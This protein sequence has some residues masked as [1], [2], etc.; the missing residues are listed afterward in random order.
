MAESLKGRHA[1]MKGVMEETEER[2][3]YLVRWKDMNGSPGERKFDTVEESHA[4]FLDLVN[5]TRAQLAQQ[6][7][8][9][10]Y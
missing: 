4:F 5:A 1:I 2:G 9:G 6:R 10:E 7:R 8:E 3:K